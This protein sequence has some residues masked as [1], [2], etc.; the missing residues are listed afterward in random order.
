MCNNI[1]KIRNSYEDPRHQIFP[2]H[3]NYANPSF[4]VNIDDKNLSCN[5]IKN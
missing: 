2:W 5:P 3:S 1:I 4:Y